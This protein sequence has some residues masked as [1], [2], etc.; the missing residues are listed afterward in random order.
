MKG[1]LAAPYALR[2]DLRAYAAEMQH[3]RHECTSSW[4]F[5]DHPIT[6][7]TLGTSPASSDQ[8]AQFHVAND[9]WDV[10]RSDVLVLFTWPF[11]L[12]LRPELGG[13]S[14]GRHVET[15]VAMALGIPVIVLGPAENIF[16]RGQGVIRVDT[17][18]EVLRHL[19]RMKPLPA[20]TAP[21]KAPHA[22][23]LRAG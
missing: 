15:G 10:Q 11:A 23:S 8:Y 18:P 14:G 22:P 1:Y 13:N 16:H 7:T 2:D 3:H 12:N 9:I 5:E 19:N 4:L 6:P 21:R 17:W 20:P